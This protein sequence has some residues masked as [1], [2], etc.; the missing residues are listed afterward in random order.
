M[1]ELKR[2][3][4]MAAET[5]GRL[6]PIVYD[7]KR[8]ILS[9]SSMVEE[10]PLQVYSSAIIFSPMN[11]IIRKLYS[12]EVPT[13][14][15]KL[16]VMPRNWSPYLQTLSHSTE[17]ETLAASPNGRLVAT[18]GG[19]AMVRIWD[20]VTGTERYVFREEN[21]YLVKKLTFSTDG[22]RLVA[23]C[24]SRWTRR[25]KLRFW[26]AITGYEQHSLICQ[27]SV[28]YIAFSTNSRL[29]AIGATSGT[30][31][32]LN[33][34]TLSQYREIKCDT[35]P[36]A[37]IIF[38]PNDHYL[39]SSY[40]TQPSQTTESSTCI[41]IGLWGV[42]T[43][44]EYY[45]CE[46]GES[47][48]LA[49]SANSKLLVYKTYKHI[50]LWDIENATENI[51]YKCDL[52]NLSSLAFLQNGELRAIANSHED[53]LYIWKRDTGSRALKVLS[54]DMRAVA[55]FSDG[56]LV[57]T[58]DFGR[59]V[60]I[61]DAA[62]STESASLD[63]ARNKLRDLKYSAF[64][65][66]FRGLN[67][68]VPS[69]LLDPFA[70]PNPTGYVTLAQGATILAA[71]YGDKSVRLFD[72]RSGEKVSV[73]R[74]YLDSV[75]YLNFSADG[76]LLIYL[77]DKKSIR[78]WDIEKGT[79]LHTLKTKLG[80][81]YSLQLSLDGKLFAIGYVKGFI[82]IWDVST[83]KRRCAL[84]IQETNYE[85]AVMGLFPRN[86][87]LV[88]RAF[89]PDGSLLLTW[90][91]LY[92]NFWNTSTGSCQISW[93]SLHGGFLPPAAAFSPNGRKV[94]FAFAENQTIQL[95]NVMT[96][97]LQ[98]K[99]VAFDQTIGGKT[100]ISFS[101]EGKYFAYNTETKIHLC[102]AESDRKLYSI[103]LDT[104]ILA[105]AFSP[106]DICTCV[107]TNRGRYCF[108]SLPIPQK[109]HLM[110]VFASRSWIQVNGEDVL[111]IHP[112]YRA[113]VGFVVGQSVVFSGGGLDR[114][115][116]DDIFLELKGDIPRM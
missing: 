59:S 2:G 70:Y 99:F 43:G 114:E 5:K 115:I 20:A 35:G 17:L 105:L 8:F 110:T 91:G 18:A 100:M 45:I 89:S 32:I 54:D 106:C 21:G 33:S 23:V 58:S 51:A 60:Q 56:R 71:E 26:D 75:E 97:E 9:H 93:D 90:S 103:L 94:A 109:P 86:D 113:R 11:S 27:E 98:N 111:C 46:T 12:H 81:V 74:G 57:V 68:L 108:N 55:S 63:R 28:E 41:N 50:R 76:K 38:S 112:E 40:L 39:A 66:L 7:A 53:R 88:L 104:E 102:D 6:V 61:W 37:H 30:I 78:L 3:F 72:I 67:P 107:V 73:I 87:S 1:A 116:K 10:A 84:R 65:H 49:F 80:T 36:V 101:P 15:S 62:V 95:F 96:G 42:A 4:R 25:Y 19:N 69:R 44:K 24:M 22:R 82:E 77:A 64:D 83:W 85:K 52:T 31:S 92:V 47:S 48:P 79:H 34:T 14:I 29:L 16:P 13:W